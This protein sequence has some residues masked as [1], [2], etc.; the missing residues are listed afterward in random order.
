MMAM[1]IRSSTRENPYLA[2]KVLLIV[3]SLTALIKK[4]LT[5]TVG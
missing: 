4:A 2:E 1:T 5:Q 3:I